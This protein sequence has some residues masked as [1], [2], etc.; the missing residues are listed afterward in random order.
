MELLYYSF[1]DVKF[2]DNALNR[3]FFGDRRSRWGFVVKYNR[4][5]STALGKSCGGHGLNHL[6]A[7]IKQTTLR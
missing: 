4:I 2:E 1:R 6:G 5:E 3:R 7:Q